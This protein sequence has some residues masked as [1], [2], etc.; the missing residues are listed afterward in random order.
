MVVLH[1]VHVHV[2]GHARKYFILLHGG[3][4]RLGEKHYKSKK[5]N[6]IHK[7][8]CVASQLDN[9]PDLHHAMYI[10]VHVA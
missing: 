3:W 6:C 1:D 5:T 2:Y 8:M 7:S 9:M 4:I 10:H